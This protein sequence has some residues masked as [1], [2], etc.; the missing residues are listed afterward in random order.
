MTWK[1]VFPYN[2]YGMIVHIWYEHEQDGS[3]IGLRDLDR[4]RGTVA[5]FNQARTHPRAVVFVLSQ[6]VECL[7]S[8]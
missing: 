5:D 6:A 3:P 7:V 2:A 4:T 1:L 8:A